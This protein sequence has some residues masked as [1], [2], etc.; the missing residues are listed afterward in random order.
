MFE[1]NGAVTI[2]LAKDSYEHHC[3]PHGVGAR[4]TFIRIWL[5]R[6]LVTR[7]CSWRSIPVT[8]RTATSG[9]PRAWRVRSTCR[10]EPCSGRRVW[11][12]QI[13]LKCRLTSSAKP[14][15]ERSV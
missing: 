12:R 3:R 13:Q 9:M 11:G 14:W 5:R 10:W 15:T 8:D 7:R 4:S 1:K 6:I 2:D